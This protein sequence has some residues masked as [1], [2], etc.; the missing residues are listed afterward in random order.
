MTI[1][2]NDDF[3]EFGD[4]MKSLSWKKGQV[5]NQFVCNNKWIEKYMLPN[6]Y[7]QYNYLFIIIWRVN[8][9]GILGGGA[10]LES[11]STIDKFHRLHQLRYLVLQ[12][13][14]AITQKS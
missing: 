6:L 5:S 11:L 3:I 7:E 4:K 12:I 1:E 9:T 2:K 10:T 14:N 13:I 8:R